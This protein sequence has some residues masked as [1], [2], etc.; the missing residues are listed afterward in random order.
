MKKIFTVDL[1]AES[2]RDEIYKRI[3][4]IY[5]AVC[6]AQSVW[7]K[8]VALAEVNRTTVEEKT[9]Y[10]L[11]VEFSGPSFTIRWICFQFVLHGNKKTR[12]VKGLSIPESGRYRESQFNRAQDWEL[13]LI[14]GV[15]E[16]ISPYRVQLKHLMKMHQTMLHL[17]KVSN[18]PVTAI[19]ISERVT[20]PSHSISDYKNKY[21]R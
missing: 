7:M 12:V 20:K 6:D 11:R 18:R 3:D 17:G 4:L 8:R 15:E 19:P 2:L 9:N 5:E 10:E 13:D 16:S 21:R 14:K 1:D